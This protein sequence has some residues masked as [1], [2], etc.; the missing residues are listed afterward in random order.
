MTV[1]LN[2]IS[3]GYGKQ[4]VLGTTTPIDLSFASAEFTALLGPNGSGKSTLLRVAAGLHRP[5]SGITTI[6]GE[7]VRS[8]PRRRLARELAFVQQSPQAPPG[9][10]VRELVGMGRHARVNWHGAWSSTDRDVVDAAMR[11]CGVEAHADRVV[12]TLSGGERQRAWIALAIAQEPKAMLLDEPISALDVKHQ[13]EVLMLIRKLCSDGM[14]AVVVLHDLNIAARFADRLVVLREGTIATDGT[15][16]EVL[17]P[18]VIQGTFEVRV[19]IR[20]DGPSGRPWCVPIEP[21]N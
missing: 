21:V 18:S 6:A 4:R 16:N 20:R 15:P 19:E 12:S 11:R 13:L 9:A 14:T 3:A 1:A 2:G 10:T 17:T 5:L 7:D 8:V